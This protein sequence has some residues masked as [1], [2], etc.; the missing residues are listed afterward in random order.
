MC[1][2]S[3]FLPFGALVLPLL[4]PSDSDLCLFL[5]NVIYVLPCALQGSDDH[6][7]SVV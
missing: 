4:A 6:L 5:Q 2:G 3:I 7:T 1:I